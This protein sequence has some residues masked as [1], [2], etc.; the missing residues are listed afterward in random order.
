MVSHLKVFHRR[1]HY[2]QGFCYENP[3]TRGAIH[4]LIVAAALETT[5]LQPL[6]TL[7]S[8]TT[9]LQRLYSQHAMFQIWRRQLNLI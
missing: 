6:H 7:Q 3:P 1:R 9:G 4:Q 8:G 5:T 2:V